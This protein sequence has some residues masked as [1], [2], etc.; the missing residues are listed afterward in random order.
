LSIPELGPVPVVLNPLEFVLYQFFLRHPEGVKLNYLQD[1]TDAILADY[2]NMKV[3]G[4][5]E[6][7]R[8]RIQDLVNPNSN[9]ASEKISRIKKKLQL[10]FG[11]DIAEPLCIS[12]GHSEPKR[13]RLN[14]RNI[15][16]C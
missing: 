15:S 3:S 10:N 1:H 11:S 9:S 6:A 12:G 14:R 5:L 7:A 8:A 13:I 16:V 4:G 2:L